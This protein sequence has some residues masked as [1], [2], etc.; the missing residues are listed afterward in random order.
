MRPSL[1]PKELA[2]LMTNAQCFMTIEVGDGITNVDTLPTSDGQIV[3]QFYTTKLKVCVS[4]GY[5]G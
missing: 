3:D 4:Y 2:V 5:H 1:E